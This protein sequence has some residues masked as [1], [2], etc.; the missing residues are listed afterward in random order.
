MSSA[1]THVIVRKRQPD[2][3]AGLSPQGSVHW[4]TGALGAVSSTPSN[5]RG[6]VSSTQLIRRI[7]LLSNGT[8]SVLGLRHIM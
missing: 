3:N 7:G 2:S 4:F 8:G 1:A 5:M 6:A